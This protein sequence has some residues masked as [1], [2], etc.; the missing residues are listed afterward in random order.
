MTQ[1]KKNNNKNKKNVKKTH[2]KKN[3][4]T[5]KVQKEKKGFT[6]I[7]LLAVI[8]ILGLL[9]AIA[10]PAVTR[11]ITQSRK[12]T[13]LKTMDSFISAAMTKA[14]DNDF[15]S[16]SD[17]TK[18]YYI[19][20]HN[21]VEKSCVGLE[22]GGID[23]FGN[24]VEAYV[25]VIYNPDEY[26]YEY[27]FTFYDDAGYG[28]ELTRED[29]IKTS[30]ITN[31]TEMNHTTI[32][33]Q[34]IGDREV[35]VLEIGSCNSDHT[36]IVDTPVEVTNTI[37]WALQDNDSNGTNETLV[38]SKNSVTG[39][40]SGNFLGTKAFINSTEIPWIGAGFNSS[41][42][43]SKDVS[44]IK[45]ESTIAPT[46]TQFWFD[47][48]GYNSTSL[49]IDINKLNT[50]NVISMD[51]MF[52]YFGYNVTNFRLDLS[53]L[54]TSKVTNMKNM[55][56]GAGYNSTTFRLVLKNWN[57]SK[58]TDMSRIFNI[59]GRNANSYVIEGLNRW[60]TSNVTNMASAFYMAGNAATT[61]DI[62]DI[63]NWN[64]SKLNNMMSMF[65]QAGANATSFKIDVGKWNVSNVTTMN[66]A[67]RYAGLNSSS[68]SIG[69]LSN[70][71]I[72]NVTD[73]CGLFADTGKNSAMWSVGDLSNWDTSKVTNMT[74]MFDYSGYK[75]TNWYVGD[76]SNW[77][78][79]KVT[80]MTCMFDY[81]GYKTTN[82]YVGNLSNWNTSKVT[83]MNNMFWLAGGQSK[84]FELDISGWNTS[85]VSNM[86]NMFR[87]TG[88]GA[89]TWK[90]KI[91][92]TNGNGINNTTTKMYGSSSTVYAD[93]PDPGRY[94]TLAD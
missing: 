80:N 62:G 4:P 47:G 7:E 34:T 94:F 65:Y 20:V 31:P 69:D 74:C 30:R 32:T 72:G 14:N 33:Q 43:R 1:T 21:E 16:M 5:R 12:K 17:P 61:W 92:K 79:S 9:V 93:Q 44:V 64:T 13:L 83:T 29:E 60:N 73:I 75:T 18:I 49:N 85:K 56:A 76:L 58:V 2:V 68:W 82:W 42:N 90:I 66:Q 24:W 39:T 59:T 19:P 84:S 46:S 22:K 3:S 38:F 23:P 37:Y 27:Y 40:Y 35:N 77:D 54:K 81:S 88:F 53:N 11:Y 78:T 48:V 87:Q 67:F 71:N 70:W 55:F 57:T 10:L 8:V 28:M 91:P 6:L 51:S 36:T 26:K 50:S 15:E 52:S 41:N 86:S 25:A 45:V 89:T 63:S